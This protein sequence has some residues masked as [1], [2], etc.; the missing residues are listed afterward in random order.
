MPLRDI[1][2]RTFDERVL[3]SRP[4]EEQTVEQGDQEAHK[5]NKRDDPTEA[6]VTRSQ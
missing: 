3:L 4:D 1:Y 6:E 2:E 5:T